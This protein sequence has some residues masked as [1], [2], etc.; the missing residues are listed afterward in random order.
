MIYVDT[1]VLVA[2]HTRE[3]HIAAA[4]RWYAACDDDLASSPWCVTEFARALAL[5]QRTGQ[6]KVAAADRAWEMFQRLCANDLQLV[7]VG[8]GTFERAAA[9]VRDA[10]LGL[11]AGDALHVAAALDLKVTGF[12]TLDGAQRAACTRLRLKPALKRP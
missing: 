4:T 8:P 9:L 1:S 2:L 10:A 6:L 12:A 7:P 11:R 3:P 5:K